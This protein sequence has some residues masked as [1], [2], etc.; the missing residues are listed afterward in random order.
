MSS[1]LEASHASPVGVHNAGDRTARKVLQ[2]GYYWPS[3]FR[4]VY[5]FVKRYDQC[6]RQGSILKNHEM[7]M[8]KM[9]EVKLFDV[10][11]I[12]SMGPFVSSFGMKY[13][14]VAVEY[15][16]KWVEAEALV[17]NEGKRVVAFQR[18]NIFSRF[19]VPRTI[20]NNG[21]S[22]FCNKMFRATL[23]K[24]GVKQHKIA[25]PYHRKLVGRHYGSQNTTNQRRKISKG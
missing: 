5:E 19:G 1:I 7:P 8:S 16:S 9:L 11:V 17:D 10:W 3:L 23:A 12:D 21:G 15:V 22:Q 14:L 13:I 24:Y 20:I 18:K 4:D 2:S 25:T 6:Q